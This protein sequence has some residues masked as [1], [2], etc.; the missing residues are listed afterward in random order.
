M[1]LISR[2]RRA[3]HRELVDHRTLMIGENGTASNAD[4]AQKFSSEV[5]TEIAERLGAQ[6]SGAKLAGQQAGRQFE[7]A[8][9][10]FL[11]ATFPF[12]QALRPG[13]WLIENVGGSRGSYRLAQYEPYRHLDDLA[14]AV[15]DNKELASALGNS[16]EI[17]P[18]IIIARRPEDDDEINSQVALVG[19]DV[20]TH[21]PL[22]ADNQPHPIVHTPSSAVS[23]HYEAI[24]RRMRGVKR[25]ALSAT[26][27]DVHHTSQSLPGSRHRLALHR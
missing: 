11:E 5:A 1:T 25:S 4:A 27:R 20:A 23:G 7:A 12:M 15:A 6:R 22:R 10:T 3:F 17:A 13:S 21:S 26:A 18:D 19:S 24:G 9:H 14:R 16:Y 8:V 2:A